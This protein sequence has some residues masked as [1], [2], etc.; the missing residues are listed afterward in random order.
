M[1][2]HNKT[3]NIQNSSTLL[4]T[5]GNDLLR[6]D[7]VADPRRDMFRDFPDVVG[8]DQICLM[9][10]GVGRRTVTALLKNKK[11]PYIRIG[12]EYKVAKPD[13]ISFVLNSPMDDEFFED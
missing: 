9:L 4:S 7:Q 10:G 11:I 5:Q 2:T 8:I 3:E 1:K 13:V 6:E 12:R